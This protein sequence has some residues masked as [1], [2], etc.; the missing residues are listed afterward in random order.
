MKLFYIDY[1][2]MAVLFFLVYLFGDTMRKQ[3][4]TPWHKMGHTHFDEIQPELRQMHAPCRKSHANANDS[5]CLAA[6]GHDSYGVKPGTWQHVAHKDVVVFSAYQD[7]RRS[8]F[9]V[10]RIIGIVPFRKQKVNLYCHLM[11]NEDTVI[12]VSKVKVVVIGEHKFRKYS[13]AFFLCKS[14]VDIVVKSV[15][16]SPNQYDPHMTILNV[17]TTAS[18][19][20][21][22]NKIAVCIS[23]FHQYN[24]S[25][26]VIEIVEIS[27]I[28]GGSLITIYN[29]SCSDEVSEVLE[30]YQKDGIVDI[31]N[32]PLASTLNAHGVK[33]KYGRVFD[34]HYG[35][36]LAALQDC[37]YRNMALHEHAVFTDMDEVLFPHKHGNWL[38]M[39]ADLQS[40]HQKGGSFVF[41]NVFFK[42]KNATPNS[43]V[44]ASNADEFN[45]TVLTNL[46]RHRYFYPHQRRSKVIIKTQAVEEMGIHYVLG[47]MPGYHEVNVSSE[48][49]LLHHYNEKYSDNILNPVYDDTACKYEKTLT[50]AVHSTLSKLKKTKP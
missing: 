20:H 47:H 8:S 46:H 42:M 38:A 2:L 30:F 23:P 27:R 17:H 25:L 35:G 18:I 36:Q 6:T 50:N 48:V 33:N 24:N 40:Q 49:G 19:N 41:Q 29:N 14:H 7:E 16:L 28:L 9:P 13:A 45:T 22:K 10:I 26:N 34:I 15:G 4:I 31:I 12:H 3:H 5:D 32:W 43:A 44:K 11:N 39:I 21:T 1:M 37:V